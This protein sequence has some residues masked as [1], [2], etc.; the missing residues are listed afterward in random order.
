MCGDRR[1]DHFTI[2]TNIK[3]LCCTPKTN[4]ML[5][6]NF[7]SIKI[8]C[9]KI[10][11]SSFLPFHHKAQGT[12]LNENIDLYRISIFH[13]KHTH[14]HT[15]QTHTHTVIGR[16]QGARLC[17]NILWSVLPWHSRPLQETYCFPGLLSK[18]QTHW[19]LLSL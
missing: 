17:R 12:S 14:T 3:S 2:Y 1:S 11:F 15:P 7:I 9:F 10:L 4:I 8:I 5:Y 6:V 16:R 13:Y 19:S 18:G